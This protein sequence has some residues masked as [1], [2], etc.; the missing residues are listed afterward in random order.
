M[1]IK[2]KKR[3]LGG[4]DYFIYNRKGEGRFLTYSDKVISDSWLKEHAKDYIGFPYFSGIRFHIR[5]EK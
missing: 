5:R 4:F 2:E 3:I 1:I